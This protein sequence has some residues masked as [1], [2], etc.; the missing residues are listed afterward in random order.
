MV[1]PLVVLFLKCLNT[2]SSTGLAHFF[3][4]TDS[5]FGFKK[6][7]GCSHAIYIARCVINHYT[8]GG[9]TVNLAALDISKAFDRVD[10][11]GLFVKLM[12]KR[13]PILLLRI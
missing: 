13:V 1:Y 9:S 11:F 3:A 10:H 12:N 5:Q 7:T 8:T 2:V 4:T 6:A